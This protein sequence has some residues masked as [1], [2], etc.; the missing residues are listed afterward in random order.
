MA[1]TQRTALRLLGAVTLGATLMGGTGCVDNEVS[2]FIRQVQAPLPM[3]LSQCIIPMDPAANRV[4]EGTLDVGLRD[5]Y[6]MAPL[7]ASQVAARADM[8][9]NRP[10]TSVISVEGFVIEIHEGSPD[11]P[12]I[13][14]PFTVY[15]SSTILPPIAGQ[16]AYGVTELQVI[17]PTIVNA[18]RAQVCTFDTTNVTAQCPVPVITSNPRRLI[19]RILA[20]GHTL[21]TGPV[22]TPVF[23]FP[24]NVCCGCL[25]NFPPDA[26]TPDMVYP[27]PDC[28]NGSAMQACN[29]GQD[30]P[31]DCRL[32]AGTN[33]TFCQPRGFTTNPMMPNTCA[34]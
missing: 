33:R 25:V 23:D 14:R 16:I 26:D 11:G 17:P 29:L 4:F 2:F 24:V 5:D 6:R 3:G 34:R 20:F 8:Q 27:G 19:V 32:C 21:G 1:R 15:Q 13:G 22:E 31:A 18:L 28:S 30:A 9:M 10:E 12:I 7:L